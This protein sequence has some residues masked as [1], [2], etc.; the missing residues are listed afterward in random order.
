VRDNIRLRVLACEIGVDG[1]PIAALIRWI[2]TSGQREAAALGY[3]SFP[4]EII[5]REQEVTASPR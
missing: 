4:P 5:D 3:G 1:L 2:L